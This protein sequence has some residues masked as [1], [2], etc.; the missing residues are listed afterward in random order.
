MLL[1]TQVILVGSGIWA[2]K[3]FRECKDPQE[4]LAILVQMG[5][6]VSKDRKGRMVQREC[7]EMLG[8]RVILDPR[9]EEDRKENLEG[10]RCVSVLT[11]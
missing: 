5:R 8:R 4:T 7:R 11:M 3:D 1:V 2:R 10:K 9:D 6:L